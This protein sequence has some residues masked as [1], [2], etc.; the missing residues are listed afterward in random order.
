MALHPSSD[1]WHVPA[2][3]GRSTILYKSQLALTVRVEDEL[4]K[5]KPGCS[6]LTGLR[7][8]V[9]S[10]IVFPPGNQVIGSW[11][12][13]VRVPFVRSLFL[14]LSLCHVM[15]ALCKASRRETETGSLRSTSN[16]PEELQTG[17]G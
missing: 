5:T 12:S 3:M 8:T 10:A 9:S 14:S 2:L 17:V 15:T 13:L 6:K 7:H 11:L 1:Y 16:Y 4:R